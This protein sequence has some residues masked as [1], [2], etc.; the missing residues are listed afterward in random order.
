VGT[1]TI[2][3]VAQMLPAASA[4]LVQA[5][6]RLATRRPSKILDVAASAL[7][8]DFDTAMRIESR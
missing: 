5:D 1:P 3:A 7:R 2:P 8:V 4:M 6:A